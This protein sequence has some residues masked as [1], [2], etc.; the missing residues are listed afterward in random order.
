MSNCP[1]GKYLGFG[2]KKCQ[3]KEKGEKL[4]PISKQFI[5]TM[6]FVIK[7]KCAE[8]D[9]VMKAIFDKDLKILAAMR[10]KYND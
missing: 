5:R 3:I 8:T 7:K 1:H 6:A 4:S 10:S 2:C 9:P